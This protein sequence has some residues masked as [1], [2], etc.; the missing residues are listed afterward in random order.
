MEIRNGGL[1]VCI[2]ARVRTTCG[3]ARGTV[4]CVFSSRLAEHTYGGHFR[5]DGVINGN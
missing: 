1:R 3:K 5:C 4:V 2:G